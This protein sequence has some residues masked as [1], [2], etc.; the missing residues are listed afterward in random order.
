MM[1]MMDEDRTIIF[2]VILTASSTV[3]ACLICS[4]LLAVMDEQR[5]LIESLKNDYIKITIHSGDL[6]SAMTGLLLITVAA[7]GCSV[8]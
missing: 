1:M 2:R 4:Q 7:L 6:K 3:I 5:R 8:S